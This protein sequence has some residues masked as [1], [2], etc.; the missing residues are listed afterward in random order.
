[1]SFIDGLNVAREQLQGTTVTVEAVEPEVP[2]GP[3]STPVV[4]SGYAQRREPQLP[5][6]FITLDGKLALGCMAIPLKKERKD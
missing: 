6:L 1:M 2:A 5:Q 4:P 3:P